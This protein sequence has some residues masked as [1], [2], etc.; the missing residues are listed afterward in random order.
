MSHVGRHF[1]LTLG[2]KP[3]RIAVIGQ[4]A[5]DAKV[6]LD[7]RNRQISDTG[8]QRRCQTEPGISVE[9]RTCAA[10]RAPFG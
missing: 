5:K 4:E 7:Q 8:I 3:L 2:D 9:I 1:D 6:G 10:R